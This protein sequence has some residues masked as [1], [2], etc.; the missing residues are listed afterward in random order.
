MARPNPPKDPPNDPLQPQVPADLAP[1]EALPPDADLEER[2]NDF[3]KQ[4]GAALFGGLALAMVAVVGW[5]LFLYLGDRREAA[6]KADYLALE[7]ME[8]RQA[9]AEA[10]DDK[11][12]GGLAFLDLAD[13]AYTEGAFERALAHYTRAAETLEATA[14]EGRAQ[15]GA[16]LTRFEQGASGRARAE[17]QLIA[18]TEAHLDDLRAEAAYH[19]AVIAL[20][21]GDTAEARQAIERVQGFSESIFWLQQANALSA[22][23]P[24]EAPAPATE[25]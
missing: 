14:F 11:L 15:L 10:H 19:L 12:L 13:A 22:R 20:E 6:L 4:N 23:L 24:D 8:A 1:G 2:F 7:T 21:A 5:Q 16:A 25:S 17:L 18:E 3:I 9:F